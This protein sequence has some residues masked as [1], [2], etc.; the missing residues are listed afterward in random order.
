LAIAGASAVGVIGFLINGFAPLVDAIAWL[1]YVSP[2]YY[3][4]GHDPIANGVDSAGIT[5]LIAATLILT[6]IAVI[7]FRRRD[8][9]P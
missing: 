4:S 3:Y 1:R 7:G 6:A 2:F 9:R 8:L 5:V